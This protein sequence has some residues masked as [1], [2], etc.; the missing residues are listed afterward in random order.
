MSLM[1]RI[2]RDTKLRQ[3]KLHERNREARNVMR[4]IHNA[5][6]EKRIH[7]DYSTQIKKHLEDQGTRMTTK[8]TTVSGKSFDIKS[9]DIHNDTI[10]E[11]NEWIPAHKHYGLIPCQLEM[12]DLNSMPS[13][14]LATGPRY[15]GAWRCTHQHVWE[16]VWNTSRRHTCGVCGQ[17]RKKM[18]DVVVAKWD[19]DGVIHAFATYGESD[20][21][22]CCKLDKKA[23]KPLGK[24]VSQRQARMRYLLREQFPGI[25]TE[26]LRPYWIRYF[27]WDSKA[28][29][30]EIWGRLCDRSED[31]IEVPNKAPARKIATPKKKGDKGEK[32]TPKRERSNSQKRDD[33]TAP[34]H[35]KP[36][37]LD[38]ASRRPGHW[39]DDFRTI[40]DDLA[41]IKGY[42]GEQR[43]DQILQDV[44]NS[45]RRRLPDKFPP[46][47]AP[48]VAQPTAPP[49]A[50]PTIPPAA[51]PTIPPSTARP[52]ARPAAPP[53]AR[54]T[55]RPAAPPAARST[56]R[57]LAR[58]AAPPAA[59]PAGNPIKREDTPDDKDSLFEDREDYRGDRAD[60]PDGYVYPWTD[61]ATSGA[62]LRQMT[63]TL[64]E[65]E[66]S[67][68]EPKDPMSRNYMSGQAIEASLEKLKAVLTEID[69]HNWAPPDWD[70]A[71][72]HAKFKEYFDDKSF[73]SDDSRLLRA[74]LCVWWA[75]DEDAS[76]HAE[77]ARG[78][79]KLL[80]TIH[81]D[82]GK[83]AL[84]AEVVHQAQIWKEGDAHDD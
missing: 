48:P 35:S 74:M 11:L 81:D 60:N 45:I 73:F 80:I 49:A 32:I 56:A 41:L 13:G 58:P 7:P 23:D 69:Y 36:Q 39:S 37:H 46:P 44:D 68:S 55:A 61:P 72:R 66:Y 22:P 10:P 82:K 14:A 67:H 15:R 59:P 38:E 28:K 21:L 77:M 70:S 79:V 65:L 9:F 47:A 71:A 78:Y 57:P 63:N 5:S 26:R 33:F 43:F 1:A 75:Y 62:Y 54:S 19:L 12:D 50:L 6:V 40:E 25:P 20:F 30:I 18:T 27:Q 51:L 8:A 34:S 64:R 17:A 53:A 52:T 4:E 29:A 2:Q 76:S 84:V 42:A 3:A 31:R 83:K 16:A 24:F